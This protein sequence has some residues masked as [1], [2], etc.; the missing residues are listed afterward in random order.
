MTPGLEK[1]L[2]AAELRERKSFSIKLC[3]T[4]KCEVFSDL[5]NLIVKYQTGTTLK[6]KLGKPYKI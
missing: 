3:Q 1:G 5:K 2:I 4:K 6:Q